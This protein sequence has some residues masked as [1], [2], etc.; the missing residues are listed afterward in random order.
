MADTTYIIISSAYNE[1]ATIA[2]S[3]E[4]V[5]KQTI[6]PVRWFIV[7]DGSTDITAEI[8][9][10]YSK[11][12][13]WIVGINKKNGNWGIPGYHAIPNFYIA[14][15]QASNLHFSYITNLDTDIVID[16]ADYYEFQMQK[17]DQNPKIGICSGVTY[18]LTTDN[19][20]KL[21]WHEPW[22]TTGGMKFYRKECLTDIEP[23]V[24]DIGWDGIDEF[25][26][27]S[28]GWETITFFELEVNHL[29][30][31]RDLERNKNSNQFYYY[32]R[33]AAMRGYPFWFV[34]L[35]F[36]KYIFQM[37]LITSI[38][39]I[40]GYI[41]SLLKNEKKLLTK[42]EVRFLRKFHLK[43]VLKKVI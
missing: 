13:P 30:K 36:I 20:K 26:A 24:A 7:N 5:L 9:D 22:H 2:L 23:L 17:M 14:Y 42:D 37:G 28:R 40:Y 12:H 6:L 29:G 10:K 18:Y 35:K 25:K 19:K 31:L 39:Y 32:G 38:K 43:R 3:I 11:L 4:S 15:E 8:I 27:M 16:R 34:T 41:I 1:S 21:V 33:S